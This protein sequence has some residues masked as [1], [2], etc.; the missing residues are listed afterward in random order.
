MN[1]QD[2]TPPTSCARERLHTRSVEYNGY[3]RQ[4]GLW[5]IEAELR[6]YRHYDTQTPTGLLPAQ[7]SVHHM[8]ITLTLDDDLTVQDVSAR[9]MSTPFGSCLEVETSLKPMVGARIG[10]G[11]RRA[12]TERIGGIQSCTHLREL[13][14]NLATAALQTIPTWHAQQTKKQG[15][16]PGGRPHYLG[17]CHAWRLDGPLVQK[18]HPQFHQPS[19]QENP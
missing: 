14:A 13:L 12:I 2:Q 1:H 16:S 6:D 11:W 15:Q 4:D 3:R 18:I 19:P 17:Q 7:A 5:D 8:A 9:M 10:S